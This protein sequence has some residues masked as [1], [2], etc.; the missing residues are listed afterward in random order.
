M[1]CLYVAI[2][3]RMVA[4]L[5]SFRPALCEEFPASPVE[6]VCGS[7]LRLPGNLAL[8][9]GDGEQGGKSASSSGEEAGRSQPGF[10][11]VQIT[12]NSC[13]D[14]EEGQYLGIGNGREGF[15]LLIKQM[16]DTKV[17]QLNLN[18]G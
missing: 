1:G 17:T 18:Q 16:A 5:L 8:D 9:K 4:G 11:K 14:K 3:V 2:M 12:N 15:Q 10:L 13:H 7:D 6:L